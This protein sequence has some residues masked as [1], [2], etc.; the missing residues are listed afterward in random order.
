MV[1]SSTKMQTGH[2]KVKFSIKGDHG[3]RTFLVIALY[4][5]M[6][7]WGALI[8]QVITK[9]KNYPFLVHFGTASSVTGVLRLLTSSH[10]DCTKLVVDISGLF[11]IRNTHSSI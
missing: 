2:K 5:F 6:M 7:Q 11:V 8:A 10:G 1:L 4:Q 3:G 9:I